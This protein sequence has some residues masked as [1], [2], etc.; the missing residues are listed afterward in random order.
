V[1]KH[2]NRILWTA[3]VVAW[4]FDLLFWEKS[5]G[6]SFTLFVLISLGA[7]IYL[8]R[9]EEK[10]PARRSWW[11]LIPIIVFAAGTFLRREPFTAFTN[12]LLALVLMGVFAHSFQ[13]GRWLNYSISDYVAVLFY[14]TVG[15]LARPI[16]ILARKN[17][18]SENE[19]N[20]GAPSSGRWRRVMPVIRGLI[21][22][23]P[24]IAIFASLLAAADP[25]FGDY[26][27]DFVDI[28][29]LE[30]LP[31]YI[32]R[33]VYILILGY[34]LAGLYMHA[35]TNNKDQKLIGEEKPWVPSFLG[36]TEAAIVLGSLNALFG[37]F[38]VIQFRYFFGGQSNIKVNGYTFAEYARR[39]FGE[40]V[41]VAFFS[42]LLFLGLSTISRRET[43][44]QRRTFSGL[45]I[46][47]V[48]LVAVILV[49]AFQRLLLYEDA[50]GFT[51]LRI[52]S[53]VFMVWLGI[54]L[55]A[56]VI[57]ELLKKQRAFALAS[58]IA[59]IGFVLTLNVI[60]VDGL[61]VRQNVQRALNAS[62]LSPDEGASQ[63]VDS[64]FDAY[65]LQSLSTDATLD[66]IEAQSNS[67]LAAYDQNELAAIL[68]CQI[69][70]MADE[71]D[72]ATWVSYHWADSR[73][74][75][76][77]KDHRGDFSAARVYQNEYGIWWVT[78]NGDR[79]PCYY[80]PYGFD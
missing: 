46:G 47:L 59:S 7:G 51:R 30:N 50:Y 43:T 4:T 67:Q 23:V 38:V 64:E 42:L 28:F 24:V 41:A 57:L 44:A 78:V 79:R 56:V 15:A 13:G 14:L 12:Y 27:E 31:E 37:S 34:L 75:R 2:P 74:W 76:S 32:F 1:I 18:T 25:I 72:Q 53:H 16:E 61:I 8:A 52:Y 40:L 5:P 35:F 55:A 80:D 11:L 6:I 68:A 62:G 63:R 3:I 49:S 69:T 48:V 17:P 58:L 29:K 33:G 70:I 77:I 21:I 20:P 39:G 45:G 22:A 65:Y 19:E 66:L 73:A 10:L 54:L 71:R 36:F 60:N 26:L 9:E